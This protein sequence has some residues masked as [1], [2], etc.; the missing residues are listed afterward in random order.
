MNNYALQDLIKDI[1]SVTLDDT[2]YKKIVLNALN[3][4]Q[5]YLN[6]YKNIKDKI[7]KAQDLKKQLDDQL[8]K[9][10]KVS[11][12]SQNANININVKTNTNTSTNT[13]T[14]AITTSDLNSELL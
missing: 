10:C 4:P 1:Y 6:D 13:E 8:D 14:N 12:L 2:A 11:F 9:K 7:E 3:N 5:T